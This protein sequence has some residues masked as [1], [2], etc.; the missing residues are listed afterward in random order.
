MVSL[1]SLLFETAL[2]CHIHD[3]E[4]K[5]SWAF[6]RLS[7]PYRECVNIKLSLG[8]GRG[9]ERGRGGLTD[10]DESIADVE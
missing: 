8:R 9:K 3:L 5:M 2:E 1:A 6:L 10:E 7:Y 4:W